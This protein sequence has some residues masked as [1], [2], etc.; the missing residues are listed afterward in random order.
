MIPVSFVNIAESYTLPLVPS[1]GKPHM[2]PVYFV[3]TMESNDVFLMAHTMCTDLVIIFVVYLTERT[4][5]GGR[6]DHIGPDCM[7]RA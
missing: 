2:T 1:I 7:G 5:M 3:K 6:T 4:E